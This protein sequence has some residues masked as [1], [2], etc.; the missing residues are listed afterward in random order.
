M[1]QCSELQININVI[2]NIVILTNA[3]PFR[4]ADRYNTFTKKPLTK[5][6]CVCAQALQLHMPHHI[7]PNYRA[8]HADRHAP[9]ISSAA[10]AWREIKSQHE[11][12][13]R[14]ATAT[15]NPASRSLLDALWQL[16]ETLRVGGT[17]SSRNNNIG[18]SSSG[19]NTETTS[20]AATPTAT[21]V[22]TKRCDTVEG[23]QPHVMYQQQSPSIDGNVNGNDIAAAGGNGV[24]SAGGVG[25]IVQMVSV[26]VAHI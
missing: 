25:R 23:A 16:M 6:T 15:G 8:V 3:K 11:V 9:R 24:G 12:L 4:P 14:I 7:N 1:S 13:A 21:A 18:S 2:P 26:C 22:V 5:S 17:E 19:S 10:A 20:A